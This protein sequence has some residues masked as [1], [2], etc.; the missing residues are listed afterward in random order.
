MFT[1][2]IE[3]R[4]ISPVGTRMLPG[5]AGA[6]PAPETPAWSVPSATLSAAR[7][8]ANIRPSTP[9][10]AS[11]S[12]QDPQASTIVASASVP[13]MIERIS[14][15]RRGREM[16]RMGRLGSPAIM[17]RRRAWRGF[18]WSLR[19]RSRSTPG[20]VVVDRSAISP[21]PRS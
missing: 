20:S 5:P 15:S 14:G 12:F 7:T 16:V 2:S 9:E 11:L 3:K 4:P 6:A 13:T 10:S 8:I 17:I 21:T 18:A 1:S 19:I